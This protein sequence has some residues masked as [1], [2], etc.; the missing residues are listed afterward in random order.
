M[1][2][3]GLDGEALISNVLKALS[4]YTAGVPLADDLTLLVIERCD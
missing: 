4:D 2:G 1:A 3:A